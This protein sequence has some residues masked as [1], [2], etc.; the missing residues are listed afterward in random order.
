MGDYGNWGSEWPPDVYYRMIRQRGQGGGGTD[1]VLA[2]SPVLWLKFNDGSGTTPQDSSGNGN[3]GTFINTPSYVDGALDFTAADRDAVQVTGQLGEPAA[4]TL[5]AWVDLDA[6]DTG[7]AEIVSLNDV[8]IRG[9]EVGPGTL[10]CYFNTSGGYIQQDTA[11]T[12]A[13]DGWH[14]IAF[15]CAPA[16]PRQEI[17]VDGVSVASAELAGAIV[18]NGGNTTIGRH[19]SD[20]NYDFDGRIHDV[21]VFP[22]ALSAEEIAAVMAATA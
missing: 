19:P 22:Y 16:I 5:M 9:D 1:P 3:H 15:V 7:G 6:V 10:A 12:L 17:Y 4:I 21:L 13:G 11:V 2:L 20:A 8:L 14:H 18:Y